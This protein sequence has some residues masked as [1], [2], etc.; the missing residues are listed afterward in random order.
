MREKACFSLDRS[1]IV[2]KDR[3]CHDRSAAAVLIIWK[4]RIE[5]DDSEKDDSPVA[6][7]S[8][9]NSSSS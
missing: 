9:D 1:R 4:H 6:G 2:E 3:A 5:F 7:Q 8:I